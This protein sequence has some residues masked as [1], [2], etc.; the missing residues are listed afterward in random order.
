MAS[1]GYCWAAEADVDGP[2]SVKPLGSVA[3][4][5]VPEL[6]LYMASFFWAVLVITGLGG[7]DLQYGRF[8][9]YEQLVVTV[10]VL[11]GAIL[12]TYVLAV[13]TL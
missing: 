3:V 12:W 5:C 6:E 13:R 2:S 8:S 10:L 7:T 11:V 9:A 4:E 1:H